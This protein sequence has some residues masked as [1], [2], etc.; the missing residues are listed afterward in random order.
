MALG[1]EEVVRIILDY[2]RSQQYF[3]AL[4]A[5]EQDSQVRLLSY[6]KE[7]DFFY[8]LIA[9]GKFDDVEKLVETVKDK[10][11]EAHNRIVGSLRKQKFLESLEAAVVPE[12]DEL[13]QVLKDIE[14]LLPREEYESLYKILSCDHLSDQPEFADWNVW[15]GRYRCFQDCLQCLSE[16]YVIEAPTPAPLSLLTLLNESAQ[17]RQL[18]RQLKENARYSADFQEESEG[19]LVEHSD[20]RKKSM[21]EGEKDDSSGLLDLHSQR[22]PQELMQSLDPSRVVEIARVTDSQAIR[23]CVFSPSGDFYALGSNSKSLKVY[24]LGGI[25]ESI[26]RD[27]EVPG[28]TELPHVFE[29]D[30]LHAGSIYSLDWSK[31]GAQI[32]TGSNDKTIKVFAVPNLEDYVDTA[33]VFSGSRC[34]SG[35][36]AVPELHIRSLPNQPG[37]VRSLCFH[38][39][40]D[41]ILFSSCS[42]DGEVMIWQTATV[43][44]IR[45]FT[46]HQGGT[47]AIAAAE[48][49]SFLISG[50]QDRFIRMWDLR[51]SKCIQQVNSEIFGEITSVALNCSAASMRR[52]KGHQKLAAVAHS[53][54]VMSVWDLTAGRLFSKHNFHRESCRS[55]EFSCNAQ[56]LASASFD[57]TVGLTSIETGQSYRIQ[58]HSGK[59]VSARWHPALPLIL[60][61]SADKTARVFSIG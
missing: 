55:V 24:P 27:E 23:T 49:A 32:A 12:P 45:H 16:L 13:A 54:G 59:V 56:W 39:M 15:R 30:S 20:S 44:V 1:T 37:T 29:M 22:S 11:R 6:G 57:Q 28:S 46:G 53:D 47:A 18:A 43:Q 4:M 36:E 51:T 17:G 8:D 52:R 26:L 5:L 19:S 7:I 41:E 58:E 40:D 50:G 48:D 25:V 38:P 35:Q 14:R 42:G 10:S 33:L 34:T 2:F 60:S 21:E 31:H 61:T 3:K 9:E